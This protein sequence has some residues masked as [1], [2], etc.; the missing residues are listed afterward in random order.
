M[1]VVSRAWYAA[2]GVV[3][4]TICFGVIFYVTAIRG[5][6]EEALALAWIAGA[7]VALVGLGAAAVLVARAFA[8]GTTRT[9][10]RLVLAALLA[11]GIVSLL[12]L[13]AYVGG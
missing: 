8:T 13:I 2:L 7:L 5:A 6:T 9:P 12:W 10:A 4:A 3:G 1:T 11:L